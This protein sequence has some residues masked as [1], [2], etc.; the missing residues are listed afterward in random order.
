MSEHDETKHEVI[1]N[2]ESASTA[3]ATEEKSDKLRQEVVIRDAGPCRKHIKVT[4]NREDIDSRINDHFRKLILQDHAMVPGFRPGK[5]PRVVVERR[6]RK[7]VLDQVRAEVLMASLEQIADDY[8]VAPL[9][10]PD[11]DP[12]KIEIPETGPLSWSVPGCVDGWDELRRRFGTRSLA[13]L[14]QPTIDY[15]E[16]GSPVPEMIAGYWRASRRKLAMDEGSAKVFLPHGQVPSVGQLFKNPALA[17][18]YREFVIK[19][20]QAKQRLLKADE[21]GALATLPSREVLL[22]QTLGGMKAPIAGL[23]TVLGGTLRG[24]LT[25]LQARAKKLEEAAA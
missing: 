24:L 21:I 10:P 13:E 8:D 6:Y 22:A 3:T 9:A 12:T 5:A 16:S 7:E 19:G 18:S 4:V 2:Q 1:E 23:V 17:A 15:A 14:L 20:G 25:V 11:I